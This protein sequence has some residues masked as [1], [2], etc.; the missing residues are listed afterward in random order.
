M[1]AKPTYEELEQRVKKL[2]QEVVMRKQGEKALRE[3]E[4]KLNTHLQNTPVEAISWDLNFRAVEWN[5][6]AETIFGY[7]K[8][9]AMNKHATELILPEETKEMVDDIFRDLI[10][11][12]GGARSTN[13]NLTKDGSR[14][15]CDWY[16]TTL[17]D[18]DGNM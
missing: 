16:N 3:S 2:E 9:E 11:E 6:A 15:I 13:E 8:A 17:K 14:I 4:H 18:A 1:A 10:S 5:P 7:S 12:K